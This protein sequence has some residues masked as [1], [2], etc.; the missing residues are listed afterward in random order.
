MDDISRSIS[1]VVGEV[2]GKAHTDCVLEFCVEDFI[3]THLG[4]VVSQEIM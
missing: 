2:M 3:Y 1:F 4:V